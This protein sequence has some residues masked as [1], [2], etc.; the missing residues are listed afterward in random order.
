MQ[1]TFI[2][3]E[4]PGDNVAL[5]KQVLGLIL[6]IQ[7]NFKELDL[8]IAVAHRVNAMEQLMSLLIGRRIPENG[9]GNIGGS[10]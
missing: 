8:A 2:N 3:N 7:H 1:L 6:Y 4:V 10:N 5:I 9:G